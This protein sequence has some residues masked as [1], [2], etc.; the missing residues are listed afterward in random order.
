MSKREGRLSRPCL[1]VREIGDKEI[2]ANSG[3]YSLLIE[4]NRLGIRE[5]RTGVEEKR[6]RE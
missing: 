1:V 4:S 5:K 3:K 2:K 6:K